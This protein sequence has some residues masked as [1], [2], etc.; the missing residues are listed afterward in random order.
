[1]SSSLRYLDDPSKAYK[2]SIPYGTDADIPVVTHKKNTFYK[3][4]S[5]PLLVEKFPV[6]PKTKPPCSVC[7]HD[8][9]DPTYIYDEQCL[10]PK[11]KVAML[12]F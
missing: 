11:S 6:E 8:F 12:S 7:H 10:M 3:P 4:R 5:N 2:Q 9:Q 1:M